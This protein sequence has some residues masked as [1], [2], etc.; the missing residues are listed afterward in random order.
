MRISQY[1]QLPQKMNSARIKAGLT[2]SY[3]AQKL[4]ISQQSYAKYEN[5]M[6]E[7]SLESLEL[8]CI[9]VHTTIPE[10]LGIKDPVTEI[11]YIVNISGWIYIL[12]QLED[13]VTRI[14]DVATLNT[15]R[16]EERSR[17]N[18]SNDKANMKTNEKTSKTTKEELKQILRNLQDGEILEIDF[19]NEITDNNPSEDNQNGE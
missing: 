6:T 17:K 1:L 7:P 9:E 13:H 12:K 10:L 19:S 14:L 11:E 18:E 8:F 15:H 3:L 16:L 2:Q 4:G 5:G